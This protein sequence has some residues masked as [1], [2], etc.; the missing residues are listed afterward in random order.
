MEDGEIPMEMY[1]L[2]SL[3][4]IEIKGLCG[5]KYAMCYFPKKPHFGNTYLRKA[6]LQ[7]AHPS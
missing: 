7:E 5:E 6:R 4:V 2:L 3:I 1:N